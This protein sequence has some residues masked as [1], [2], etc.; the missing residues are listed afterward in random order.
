[1]VLTVTIRK[2]EKERGGAGEKAKDKKDKNKKN[3]ISIGGG[4]LILWASGHC[5]HAFLQEV[6]SDFLSIKAM[7]EMGNL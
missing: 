3:P 1:M 2:R 4:L 6:Y 5:G 7:V